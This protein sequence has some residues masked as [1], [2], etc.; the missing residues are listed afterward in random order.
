MRPVGV[1]SGLVGDLAAEGLLHLSDVHVSLAL[2]RICGESDE[3]V[4]L[5]AALAVRAVRL[6]SVCVD[7]STVAETI[8]DVADDDPGDP[9]QATGTQNQASTTSSAPP[10]E[11]V[12][13]A[14]SFAWPGPEDWVDVCASSPLVGTNDADRRPLHLS[15]SL[16]YLDRY[17]QDEQQVRAALAD[18]A[19]RPPPAVDEDLLVEW[20]ERLFPGEAPDHQR[21][22]AAAACVGWVTI[23]AGG[24]GTGKTTTVARMLTTLN[25]V[26]G[27]GLRVALAAPTGRA[28]ARLEESVAGELSRLSTDGIDVPRGL[29]ASTVHRLLGALPDTRTRFRR[30]R[31]NHLPHDV[32]VID[33]AS[34]L[35]LSMVARLLEALRPDT[36]LVLVGDPDQLVSVEAGAVLGDLA[37][38]P[39][40]DSLDARAD[41][42][43]ELLPADLDPAPEVD[44]ELRTDVVRLRRNYRF[45]GAAGLVSLADAVRRG[46]VDAAADVL[47]SGDP[48]VEFVEVDPIADPAGLSGLRADIV[49][50]ARHVV[51]AARAGDVAT[52]MSSIGAHRL[53]CA[54]RSGPYG[55]ARW[56]DRAH[57]WLTEALPGY[58]R[59][60]EFY[61]GR[62]LLV[63]A[64]DYDLGVFNGDLGVIVRLEAQDVAAFGVDGPFVPTSLLPA[65]QTP[66][67]MTVHKAQ[68]SEADR[69]TVILPPAESPLITRELLYTA[70]T[71]ARSGVRLIGTADAVRSAVSRPVVRASG[72][73][74]SA[75]AI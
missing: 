66:H 4:L 49:D 31:N 13:S 14:H 33:E 24:P 40:R 6:G 61:V 22:A 72:L 54:H 8:G 35:P 1:A 25:A 21:L 69:V 65:V 28:A 38:R 42:L 3:R 32:V 2:A 16:L 26:A 19:E 50:G 11:P 7:L 27:G 51:T 45:S 17:W 59:E 15:G 10:V 12:P 53:L 29:G 52:A 71:R 60:G 48:T 18:W 57:Q 68:G 34:M 5:G 41:R 39:P 47:T 58:G 44:E 64:N 46:D 67:A 43:T 30:N 63:T 62:P 9:Q 55:I 56:R 70:I 20:L 75:E 73:R 23:V 36:R 37:A 74:R